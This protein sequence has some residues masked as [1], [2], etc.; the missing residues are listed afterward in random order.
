M[1]TCR[2]PILGSTSAW[3]ISKAPDVD[4][5]GYVKSLASGE[6][7]RYVLCADHTAGDHEPGEYVFTWDGSGAIRL[8]GGLSVVSRQANSW[9]LN[10][11]QGGI[12]LEIS[13]M[14]ADYPRNFK[15]VKTANS[16]PFLNDLFIDSVS[17]VSVLRF[18]D[19]LATN[20][21]KRTSILPSANQISNDGGCAPELI[22]ETCNA[23]NK[24]A[25]VN[26]PHLAT[27]EYVQEFIRR[28]SGLK[29]ELKIYVEHS[30]E[31]WNGIFSQS[32]YC[33]S[34]GIARSLDTNQWLA[35]MYY[36]AL[37]SVEIGDAFKAAFGSSRVVTVLGAF[38]ANDWFTGKMLQ[39]PGI[40]EK[41][42]AVAIAPYFGSYT[43]VQTTEEILGQVPA[44]IELARLRVRNNKRH[45]DAHPH[46]K[47]IAYE[48]GQHILI[49]NHDSARTNI[50][51]AANEDPR[52]GEFYTQ[53]LDMWRTE[54][55]DGLFTHFVNTGKWTK[56]GCWGS[57]RNLRHTSSHKYVALK[58]FA[59]AQ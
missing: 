4:E 41:V 28:L 59:A 14:D 24:H 19:W 57:M 8:N 10:I 22:V 18:M 15:M 2:K 47:L 6:I 37:R 9:T 56:W 38:A 55:G 3:Q 39:Y 49:Q 31:C 16:H 5:N 54:S 40:A 36:H 20:D 53:Y 43:D 30:N 51:I 46:I 21:S 29:P 32:Q 12:F 48:G 45:V 26:I 35:G 33:V 25:W 42:D 50:L 23:L 11:T 13:A 27:A 44:W 1:K 17:H 58:A 34:Q 7:A 52:M